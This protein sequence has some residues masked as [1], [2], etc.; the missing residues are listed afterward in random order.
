MTLF[1]DADGCPVVDIAIK[2]AKEHNVPC[3]LI[4]DTSHQIERSVAKTI[5]VSKGKDSADFMILNMIK[6]QDV[7]I[8]QDYG[9]AAMCLAKRALVLNQN[10]LIYTGENIDSLLYFRYESNKLLNSGV[11]LRGPK[12]REKS[13]DLDFESALRKILEKEKT[14]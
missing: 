12:K 3:V 7:V 2:V 14:S 6:S 10:G 5:T 9:L 1:I 8:T 13:Q 11:R 4:C